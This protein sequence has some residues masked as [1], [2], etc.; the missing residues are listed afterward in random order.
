MT[1]HCTPA[2][3]AKHGPNVWVVRH[4]DRFSVKEEGASAYLIPPVKQRA[5]IVIARAV[6]R[7]N[8]SELII[9]GRSGR[10]RR[11]DSH[12]FDPFPPRG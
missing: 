11:R 7:A 3:P 5:A 4:G 1:E 6:A 8:K 10:I 9:Q 12:G 2:K